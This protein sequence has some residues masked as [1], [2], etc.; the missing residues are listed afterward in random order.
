MMGNRPAIRA[1][2]YPDSSSFGVP[3]FENTGEPA[4]GNSRT[5]HIGEAE[6]ENLLAARPPRLR[7][8]GDR[9]QNPWFPDG[10][11][12]HA[13]LFR[14]GMPV[15]VAASRRAGKKY[16][17]DAF[18]SARLVYSQ[19]NMAKL[20]E[21][22]R[23]VAATAFELPGGHGEAEHP[24]PG[25]VRF[26]IS[27]GVPGNEDQIR[28]LA[29]D[30]AHLLRCAWEVPDEKYVHPEWAQY[31]SGSKTQVLLRSASVMIQMRP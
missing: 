17:R 7:T 21:P 22:L 24:R 14:R 5:D 28:R 25:R 10:R 20:I 26:S 4:H 1:R 9:D 6:G 29:L 16:D 11:G 13:F 31:S 2:V 15:V 19:P 3:G 8:W 18:L 23:C 30:P 12:I 27:S